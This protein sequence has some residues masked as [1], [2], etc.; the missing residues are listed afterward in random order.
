SSSCIPLLET[1]LSR[2]FS[3][4]TSGTSSASCSS[5][6]SPSRCSRGV[7]R[8]AAT[9]DH[10]SGGS[11]PLSSGS[12]AIS[13]SSRLSAD[14]SWAG[15]SGAPASGDVSSP[16]GVVASSGSDMFL[17][18]SGSWLP[19]TRPRL[20]TSTSEWITSTL[21]CSRGLGR[22]VLVHIE[23]R[24]LGRPACRTS[25]LDQRFPAKNSFFFLKK[26]GRL[27]PFTWQFPGPSEGSEEPK[28]S[29]AGP[30][31]KEVV[32]TTGEAPM[33]QHV[34]AELI[35]GPED[36]RSFIIP[37]LETNLPIQQFTFP[38]ADDGPAPHARYDRQD[39]RDDGVWRYTYAGEV[40]V[41]R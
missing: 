5:R 29:R 30:M 18:S 33:Q 40:A 38:P 41:S 36:G 27:V 9:A 10:C 24:E 28:P 39:M 22:P 37:V 12:T 8:R 14:C 16:E 1:G 6:V 19:S 21:L 25:G 11:M 15:S 2:G 31:E 17:T 13:S 7:G 3:A 23:P 4:E 26:R 34:R 20:I 35:G 32:S